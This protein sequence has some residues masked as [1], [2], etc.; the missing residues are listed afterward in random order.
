MRAPFLRA[1]YRGISSGG[2]GIAAVPRTVGVAGNSQIAA[3]LGFLRSWVKLYSFYF[4]NVCSKVSASGIGGAFNES[5]IGF[6]SAGRLDLP[7]G[8]SDFARTR[9]VRGDSDCRNHGTAAGV[10]LGQTG[11]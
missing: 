7:A 5:G 8:S 9:R 10:W 1:I 11:Q 2:R 6:C 3:V 4:A